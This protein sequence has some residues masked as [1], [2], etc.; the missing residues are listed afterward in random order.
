MNPLATA[1]LIASG[2]T[3]AVMAKKIRDQKKSY[4]R[5]LAQ[6]NTLSQ[7]TKLMQDLLQSQFDQSDDNSIKVPSKLINDVDAFIIFKQNNIV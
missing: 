3:I 5:L 7:A 6:A 1:A 2:V 4:L